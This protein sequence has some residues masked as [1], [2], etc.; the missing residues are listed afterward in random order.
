MDIDNDPSSLLL[1]SVLDGVAI[2]SII[3][4]LISALLWQLM[5][6]NILQLLNKLR[7]HSQ[8][9]QGKEITDADILSWANNKVKVSGRNS[10]MESFKV[11]FY[12]CTLPFS[13][14][15]AC[16]KINRGPISVIEYLT[17]I[18]CV[19]VLPLPK[20]SKLCPCLFSCHICPANPHNSL[21][22]SGQ[23]PIEWNFFPWASQCCRAKGCELEGC[24]EGCKWCVLR[25]QMNWF[26]F[27][28]L[29]F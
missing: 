26:S 21:F 11:I 15:W 6:F 14:S 9:S 12:D 7:F 13:S 3:S 20:Q 24:I 17:K 25:P 5:R 4:R 22:A 1:F 19:Y 23:E 29:T 27:Y 16:R 18:F 10:R 28:L 8:G 2:L